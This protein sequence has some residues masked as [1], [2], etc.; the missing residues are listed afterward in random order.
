MRLTTEELTSAIMK[1]KGLTEGVKRVPGVLFRKQDGVLNICYSDGKRALIEKIVL[2]QTL[3]ED[4]I[5]DGEYILNFNQIL[6]IVE[7]SQPSGG[8]FTD[9]LAFSLM[10]G[11]RINIQGNKL[12]ELMDMEGN[13]EEKVASKI[14]YTI[15]YSNPGD[16]MIFGLLTKMDYDSIFNFEDFDLW[17]INELRDT[18]SRTS[19]EKGKT[20]YTS[21]KTQSA[22]VSNLAY[23]IQIPTHECEDHGFTVDTIL[24]KA[25]VDMLGKYP[26]TSVK[27]S[28]NDKYVSLVAHDDSIGFWFEMPPA[29]RTDLTTLARYSNKKYDEY[30]TIINRP[31]LNNIINCALASDNSEKTNITFRMTEEGELALRILCKSNT[32]AINDYNVL[33]EHYKDNVGDMD[34][35]EIQVSL[36]ILQDI[37]SSCNEE[38]IK[39]DIETEENSVF[40]KITGIIQDDA[41]E[42]IDGTYCYSVA[43][44]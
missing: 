15:S 11:N 33:V 39:L 7:M 13:V 28:V 32:S 2:D 20:I 10:E 38:Y 30:Q 19:T 41:G 34:K 5:P 4:N 22:F 24:A 14:K 44:K 18:L 35:L 21:S 1:I 12:V 27:V 3:F 16:S 6:K 8:I 37:V 31:L 43:S 26:G 23:L 36:K 17:T 9:G 25:I 40:L 29:N 42:I